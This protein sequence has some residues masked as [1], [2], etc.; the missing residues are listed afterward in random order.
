MKN[1][2]LYA[3]YTDV[4][5]R[6]INEDS[7]AV[8]NGDEKTCCVV[9]DGLGGHGMGD[10]ASSLIVDVFKS[11]F[12][13]M[14][15]VRKFIP[16]TLQASQDVLLAEQIKQNAKRKMKSTAVALLLDNKK[17]YIGHIGDTR[18]YMF[19]KNSVKFRTLDHSVPQMLVL[20]NQITDDEIR[21]HPDRNILLRVMGID[22]NEPMYEI[23]APIPLRKCQA[24]LLCTDGFWEL[25]TEDKMCE[26]LKSSKT[27]DGW[28]NSM[29]EIVKRNGEDVNMDNNSAIAVW[30][31]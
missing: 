10:V 17:A 3:C 15:D 4:G 20:S 8:I 7:I 22:W 25:I 31:V 27:V 14:D 16:Q 18:L 28:L 30:I 26:L 1:K 21:N 5:N 13:T 19:N 24:F 23:S 6:A 9:C 29:V 11:Q 2:V 12:H